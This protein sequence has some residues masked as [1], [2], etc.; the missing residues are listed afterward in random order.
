[1]GR[2]SGTK[3][4]NGGP[5]ALLEGSFVGHGLAEFGGAAQLAG[6]ESEPSQPGSHVPLRGRLGRGRRQG[7]RGGRLLSR[8]PFAAHELGPEGLLGL[9]LI[10]ATAAKTK[11]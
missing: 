2:T 1:V 9:I 3:E 5:H 10:V 4:A 7:A 8:L 11:P 6:A